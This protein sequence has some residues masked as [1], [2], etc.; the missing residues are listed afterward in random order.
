MAEDWNISTT[1]CT[2]ITNQPY[3]YPSDDHDTYGFSTTWNT[4]WHVVPNQLW[5][6]FCTPKD[7]MRLQCQYEA[8]RIK[9]MKVTIFNMIPMT[10]QL[11]IQGT[12]VFTAFNNCIYGMGYQ[13]K[14]YE[15]PI[16]NWLSK[17]VRNNQ[18]NLMYK[19][20]LIYQHN[21]ATKLKYKWPIYLWNPPQANTGT[22]NTWSMNNTT[23]VAAWP[24]SDTYPSGLIWDPLN[25]PDEIMELRPGKNAMTY[26]WNIHESDE[27]KWYNMDGIARIGPW[28]A[29]GPFQSGGRTGTYQLTGRDDPNQ[30]SSRWE[31]ANSCPDYTLPNLAY[32]PL[33]PSAWFWHEM[34][35]SI[36]QPDPSD[37]FKMPD[38][39]WCGT[40]WEQIKYPPTQMFIK[41]LPLFDS[42]GNHISIEANIS[43]KLTLYGEG[44]K[45]RSSIYCPTQ[46]PFP[47][48]SV[49][50]AKSLD[51][52]FFPSMIRER[53][54]GARRTWQNVGVRMGHPDTDVGNQ[55]FREYPYLY[56]PQGSG[57]VYPTTSNAGLP[58]ATF[59]TT[60]ADTNKDLVVTFSKDQE[61]VVI[62]KPQ[63]PKPPQRR[64]LSPGLMLHTHDIPGNI[65]HPHN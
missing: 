18:N 65:T 42:E 30:F 64:P 16:E 63:A 3:L 38:L 58:H 29:T 54:G 4:G 20:G 50:S 7:W 1:Y 35:N 44:K 19:E 21:T 39:N 36:I 6:H 5:K 59:T 15:T 53:T 26:T 41:M 17:D 61:R 28:T 24:I 55:I 32:Q 56:K 57:Q 46:G 2:Y 47:W 22:N 49:Y 14:L 48:R 11:A 52:N 33:F 51:L 13:D 23:Q 9:G 27:G 31:S 37:N 62:Q 8:Y 34:K 25:S 12:N 40:E 45:R 10:T 60:M 43:V